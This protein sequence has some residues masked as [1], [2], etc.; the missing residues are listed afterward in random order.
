MKLN[1]RGKTLLTI[2]VA[3]ISL[4]VYTKTGIW[5]AL[6]QDS[7]FYQA[8]SFLAWVWLVFGQ[9]SVYALIWED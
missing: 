5:G 3:L 9:I 1:R 7:T 6:A 8:V 4:F 2:I